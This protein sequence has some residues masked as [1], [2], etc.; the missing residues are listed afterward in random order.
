MSNKIK[1]AILGYGNL[2]KGVELSILKNPDMSLEAVFSRR[3]PKSVKTI[4]T[5]VY[6]VE[7]ILD[8]K[9]KIDVLILCGGSKDDLPVQTPEFAQY[10]N[11][12]DSYDNHAQ[13]PEY[14]A[15]VDAVAQKSK[16]IAMI[17]VGWDPGMFSINRLFGE[18]LLPDGETYTFWGKGLSQGHSDAIRRVEG[19]KAGV[20]YTLPST[21]AIEEVRSGV[22][23]SL[24]TKDKHTRECF[25]VLK[26]GADASKIENE[27]KTMPNY[28]E[29]Y[30]TSVNFI[31]QEEF[32][33]NHN[34]MPHGGFVIRSGNSSESINQV[35]EYSLKLDSNPEFTASVI[36]AYTRAV[37][38]MALK[39][40]FGAKSVLDVAPALL[41][42]KSNETLRKELL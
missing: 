31:S 3:D 40:E 34:T 41:S 22:R 33:K 16:K 29:P 26:D 25:I 6:S 11:T 2:G 32:D 24:S 23:P 20:Q 38:K 17:S 37:Y 4:N 36:V 21:K 10:F 8:Y 28:F 7:N 5:P 27:I 1:V 9:D 30:D 13:I 42:I 14:F 15:S 18:A 35:I 39:G 19:V 12:V